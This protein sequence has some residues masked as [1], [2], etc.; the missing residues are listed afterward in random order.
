MPIICFEFL[1]EC[2]LLPSQV[3][4]QCLQQQNSRVVLASPQLAQQILPLQLEFQNEPECLASNIDSSNGQT[5]D[6][7]RHLY[8][9]R[10][11]RVVKQ[12]VRCGASAGTVQVI[13]SAAIR[14]WDQ[15]W[16]KSCQCGG[17]WRMQVYS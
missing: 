8:L 17:L 14:A 9:G 1:D 4:I 6:S 10:T 12:C 2:C 7:I 3:Q 16:L 13:R 15:R 11:P 5:V